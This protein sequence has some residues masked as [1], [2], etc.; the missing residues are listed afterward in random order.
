MEGTEKAPKDINARR[1]TDFVILI[2]VSFERAVAF[3][4]IGPKRTCLRRV[5]GQKD[6]RVTVLQRVN[7]PGFRAEHLEAYKDGV[8]G[9][10][11]DRR[12]GVALLQW[13]A[14]WKEE[15]PNVDAK[16]ERGRNF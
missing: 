9:W 13:L 14:E 6:R 12:K 11:A 15:L 10:K 7:M 8:W 2:I 16:T 4:A 5:P 3:A 1:E